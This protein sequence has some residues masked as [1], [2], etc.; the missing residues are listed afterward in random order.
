MTDRQRLW[1]LTIAGGICLGLIHRSGI[2][3]S[4]EI[5]ATD[6]WIPSCTLSSPVYRRFIRPFESCGSRLCNPGCSG[7]GVLTCCTLWRSWG[8]C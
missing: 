5:G 7:G 1:F 8:H 4:S 6:L 3:P 2:P